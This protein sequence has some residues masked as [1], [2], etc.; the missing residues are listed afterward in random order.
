MLQAVISSHYPQGSRPILL[1][2]LMSLALFVLIKLSVGIELNRYPETIY[3][4]LAF[5]FIAQ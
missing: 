4:L 3:T 5:V 1:V 2:A